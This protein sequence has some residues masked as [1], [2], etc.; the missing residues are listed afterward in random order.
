MNNVYEVYSWAPYA[1]SE[2]HGIF[3]CAQSAETMAR[4]VCSKYRN[5][6]VT[7]WDADKGKPVGTLIEFN[8]EGLSTDEIQQIKT[9]KK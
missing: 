8:T 3:I 1:D 2:T 5:S 9:R 4:E 7:E 6:C